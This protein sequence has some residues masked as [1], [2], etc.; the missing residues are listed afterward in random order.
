M[1]ELALGADGTFL[2]S[3]GAAAA[4]T[5]AVPG[6]AGDVTGVGDCADGACLDGSADGGTYIRLY[7]GDSHYL[8]LNPGNITANRILTTR[9]A[10]GTLLLSGDTLTGDVT[11]TFDTD[12]TTA[13]T[14]AGDSVALTTDTTG[15]YVA[16][17]T[18][19]TGIT[20]GDGG[21]EGATLTL[22]AT[23]GTAIDSTE[24]TD[25]VILEADLKAVD[26]ASDED[27]LTYEVTTGDFEWHSTADLAIGTATSITDDLI[28]A[29]D[30][31]DEDW[32]DI[33]IATNVASVEDDSHAHVVGNIDST[34][35][36]A[37]AGQ[38]SDESGSGVFAFTTSPVFTTPTLGVA[39]STSVVGSIT[40][41][42]NPA[43]AANTASPSALGIIFE[44]SVAD[45]V[46][47]LLTAANP[48][49]TDKTLTLQNVTGTIYST[50]GTDVA[51][52]DGGTGRS[53]L[54]ANG[55]LYGNTTTGILVTT[56]HTTNGSLLI[57][58]AQEFR[59]SAP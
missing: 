35:S 29:A 42:G 24:I 2:K 53:T 15:N 33:T 39:S 22:A 31:A 3:N 5:F 38:I 44:G 20:G 9:D 1:T 48:T 30:F 27:I 6:G 47:T 50:G 52:A 7:D 11:A 57:A 28:V 36:A 49:A 59:P 4:P 34:T 8:E 37:W 13:T 54:L 23:L 46:E 19:G 58:M 32:G 25:N 14:I 43:L 16:S 41:A 40:L 55:A 56:A 26:A 51:V 17:I 10:A 45:T 21:S 12:G 18:N